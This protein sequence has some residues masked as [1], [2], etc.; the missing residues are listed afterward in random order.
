MPA[1]AAAGSKSLT[2]PHSEPVM[3]LSRDTASQDNVSAATENA[4]HVRV[5]A[6]LRRSYL[7]RETGERWRRLP[8]QRAPDAALRLRRVFVLVQGESEKIKPCEIIVSIMG[9][10]RTGGERGLLKNL[11]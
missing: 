4:A 9:I 7:R 1:R 8:V 5:G 11:Q 3:T 6:S 2:S 10:G